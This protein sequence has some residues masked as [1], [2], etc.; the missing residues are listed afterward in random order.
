MNIDTI[1]RP[2]HCAECNAVFPQTPAGGGAAGYAV[3]PDGRHI[4]YACADVREIAQLKD[5][6]KP[7]YAYV[8][9]GIITTWTGG[10]LMTITA[11]RP[12][13]LTRASNWHDKG[14]FKSIH[15]VDV[16]GGHWTGRGSEG[17]AIKLRAVKGGAQ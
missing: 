3:A 16:H 12:C 15:A 4:C 8:G 9:K 17:L 2:A 11:S 13:A 1:T 10:K 7:F 6:S 5:R 14:S